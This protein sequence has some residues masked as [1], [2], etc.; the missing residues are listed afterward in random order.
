MNR[1]NFLVYFY[2]FP[3]AILAIN[4]DDPNLYEQV[5]SVPPKGA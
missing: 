2:I 4:F 3:Q 5:F 1:P